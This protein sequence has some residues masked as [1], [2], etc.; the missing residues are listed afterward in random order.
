MK[1]TK[2]RYDVILLVTTRKVKRCAIRAT[3]NDSAMQLAERK[4]EHAFMED[5]S[6]PGCGQSV[7]VDAVKKDKNSK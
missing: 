1:K 6:Y 4:Y 3:D 5:G 7:T 2:C